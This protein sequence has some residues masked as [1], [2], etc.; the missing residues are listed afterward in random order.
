MVDAIA[1]EG[2]GL[3]RRVDRR[4]LT[5]LFSDVRGFT[6]LSE[7]L[8][9]EV[10]VETLNE[11]LTAMVEIVFAHGGTL[12]KYIGD[13]L[14]AFF[15]APLADPDHPEHA[16]RAGLDMLARLED[17]NVD[18]AARG[19]PTL[20]IGV[21]IHTGEAVVGFIGD[22]ERRMD[23]TAIGDT[24]NLASRLEGM[25]KELGTSILVS[26]ATAGRL[27]PELRVEPRG[28]VQVK[29]REQSVEVLTL[30]MGSRRDIDYP[31]P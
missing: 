1:E 10:V 17:L 9:P 22:E 21:G 29:G 15:G 23:Y 5:I 13:G 20:R 2:I 8:D 6:T 25:N 27:P 28:A 7:G 3:V 30:E 19:R 26:A 12:D 18:W 14:M 4:E 11:Y 31:R 16:V 24:V